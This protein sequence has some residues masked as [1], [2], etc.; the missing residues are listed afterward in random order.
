MPPQSLKPGD[1]TLADKDFLIQD[2]V[3]NGVSINIPTFLSQGA[4]RVSEAKATKTYLARCCIQVE[5]S[6][7]A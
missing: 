2:F 1:M 5:G 3:H 4:F 7:Q 6:M